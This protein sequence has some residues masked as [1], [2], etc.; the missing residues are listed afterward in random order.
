T[1]FISML[2]DV[3]LERTVDLAVKLGLRSYAEEGTSGD[4]SIAQR[5]K[6]EQTGSFVLGPTPVDPLEL[7]N[8]GAT[9]ADQGRWCEPSPVS[10]VT[11][12]S[13]EKVDIP[14]K[15]CE[16]V[17]NPAV[18][19]ALANGMAGDVSNGTAADAARATGWS[20]P[21]SA[22]TG[23]TET[24]NSAAFL[25]FTPNVAGSSYIFTDSRT[26]SSLRTSPVRQCGSRDRSRGNRHHRDQQLCSLPGLHP[27]RR[28]QQLYLQRLRHRVEPVHLP[29]SPVRLRQ[30]LRRQ[31]T[32]PELLHRRRPDRELLWWQEAAARTAEA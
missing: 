17:L 12:A 29:S 6:E 30:P 4:K 10:S 21:I 2:Q 1:P 24:S 19:N 25:G 13:G 28:R 23:T 3:G 9:L 7:T 11:D 5:I 14:R 16:K 27:E 22:K 20:G 31:R 15:D 26:A 32:C 18:A 8:V